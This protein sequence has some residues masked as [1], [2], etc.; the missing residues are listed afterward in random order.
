MDAHCHAPKAADRWRG[1]AVGRRGREPFEVVDRRRQLLRERRHR[2][3][4]R[5]LIAVRRRAI[6]VMPEG[7]RQH[8]RTP[9]RRGSGPS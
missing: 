7:E 1:I 6:F 5:W 4:A 3:L 8:L 2:R 9:D